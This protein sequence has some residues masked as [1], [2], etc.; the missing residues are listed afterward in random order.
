VRWA[1]GGPPGPEEYQRGHLPGAVFVDLDGELAAPVTAHSGRHPLPAL[2]DLQRA[3]RSWGLRNASTVVL[4]DD[5]AG[6]S[7]ARGWWLLRWAGCAD[8]RLLDGGLQAWREAGF[9][10]EE[11]VGV[12]P[13]GDVTLVPGRLPVVD[14]GGA[15]ALAEGGGLLLDARAAQRFAGEVASVDPV[16]GHIPGAVSAPTADNVGADGRFRSE[17]DLAQRFTA[18]GVVAGQPVGVYCGSGVTAAHEIAAMV[19]AGVV[20]ADDVALYPGSYSQWAVLPGR[21]V[22]TGPA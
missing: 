18:L 10:V 12:V 14:A 16:P 7:A 6:M 15:A 22:A 1:L 5:N 19:V 11:G 13:E 9:A 8:V 17:A 20:R 21:P 2:D 4:Y 3:A